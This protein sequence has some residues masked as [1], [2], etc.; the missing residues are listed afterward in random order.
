[1]LDVHATPQ[2]T[3][4]ELAELASSRSFREGIAAAS[5]R[6]TAIPDAIEASKV[7][8]GVLNMGRQPGK[9]ISR[10]LAEIE[11]QGGAPVFLPSGSTVVDGGGAAVVHGTAKPV[12]AVLNRTGSI[13]SDDALA[14]LGEF[15]AKGVPVMN[16]ADAVS[17]VRDKNMQATTLRD[18]GVA[19]PRTTVV[20]SA[21]DVDG[22]LKLLGSTMVLKNPASSEGRG[23]MFLQGED[24]VRGVANLFDK[25]AEDSRLIATR[26][27]GVGGSIE[28]ADRE[29][30]EDAIR[31]LAQSTAVHDASTGVSLLKMG[32]PLRYTDSVTGASVVVDQPV[33][34]LT[35]SDAFRDAK[36]GAS[37]KAETWY[38]EAA[39]ADTRVHVGLIDGEHRVLGAMERRVAPNEFGDARSN[40]SLGGDASPVDLTPEEQQIAINGAKAFGLDVAGVDLL[41]ANGGPVVLEVNGSPGLDIEK[42]TGPI[43]DRWI[44]E[45]MRRGATHRAAR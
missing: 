33:S 22:A 25:R 20:D 28:L 41:K 26:A 11:R 8:V 19:I 45:A 27:D 31:N 39:G 13:I 44:G 38:K 9:N 30:T 40:L 32:V 37:L 29:S 4:D 18:A 21:A 35:I 34:A 14:L 36:P 5:P 3:K 15:E 1:V 2:G 43:A 6:S 7:Q 23:V 12:D 24:L 17:L 10:T 42:T 16:G